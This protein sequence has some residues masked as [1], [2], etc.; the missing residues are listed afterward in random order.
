MNKVRDMENALN[1]FYQYFFS[2]RRCA[3]KN[4]ETYCHPL[5]KKLLQK[6]E[7]VLAMDGA[8]R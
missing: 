5:Q 8:K 1:G 3:E 4:V 7:H 6:P 2:L